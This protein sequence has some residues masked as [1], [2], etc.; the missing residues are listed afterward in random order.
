MD[1][2][3]TAR[4]PHSLW[5]PRHSLP[6][7]ACQPLAQGHPHLTSCLGFRTQGLASGPHFPLSLAS[8]RISPCLLP[9]PRGVVTPLRGCC[10]LGVVACPG[11]TRVSQSDTARGTGSAGETGSN[12]YMERSVGWCCVPEAWE[13]RRRGLGGWLYVGRSGEAPLK[14]QHLIRNMNSR[15]KPGDGDRP[16][17]G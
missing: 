15:R 16:H 3:P 1:D 17:A 9:A 5:P 7:S 8:P 6:S 4:G 10:V 2:A 13:R 12:P 11:V 14:R